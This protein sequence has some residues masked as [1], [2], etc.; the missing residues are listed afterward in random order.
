MAAM[1]LYA[2]PG[3]N[4]VEEGGDN[5]HGRILGAVG[6]M[7]I[8]P[9][10]AYL[11]VHEVIQMTAARGERASNTPTTSSMRELKYWAYERD[12]SHTPALHRHD[13]NHARHDETKPISFKKAA[14]IAWGDISYLATVKA[15]SSP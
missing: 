5:S 10:I 14:R 2:L 6:F 9:E 12:P 11:Q 4:A 1:S 15:V 8:P 13:A 3:Y 7:G